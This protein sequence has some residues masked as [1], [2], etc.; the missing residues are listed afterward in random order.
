M[1]ASLPTARVGVSVLYLLSLLPL[2]V[3][4]RHRL[5]ASGGK[6]HTMYGDKS[7]PGLTPRAVESV[8]KS[9]DSQSKRGGDYSVSMYMAEL[10]LVS[11]PP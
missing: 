2:L 1:S 7:M 6:T 3:S 5:F 11:N 10:Y 8:W 4:E 9:I